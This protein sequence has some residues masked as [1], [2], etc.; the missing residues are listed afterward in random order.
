ML[1]S[2]FFSLALSQQI[3]F[4]TKEVLIQKGDSL[5][6]FEGS[7]KC[8]SPLFTDWDNDGVNDLLTGYWN[9]EDD[10]YKD[11]R[12]RFYKNKGTNNKPMFDSWE[13]VKAGGQYINPDGN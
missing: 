5:I 13:H 1:L 11:G 3:S 7:N 4:P 12:L 6:D 2:L 8:I 9:N 10:Y